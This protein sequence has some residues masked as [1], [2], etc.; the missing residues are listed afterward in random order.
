MTDTVYKYD[1]DDD[2]DNED[3]NNDD[4]DR[5]NMTMKNISLAKLCACHVGYCTELIK[6]LAV[7]VP[8]A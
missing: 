4:Y 6:Q 8:A 7:L 1:D 2:N 3:N 5:T